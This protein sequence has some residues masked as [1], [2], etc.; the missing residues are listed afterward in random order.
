MAV[1][2]Q[3]DLAM[4]LLILEEV[5]PAVDMLLLQVVPVLED[6]VMGLQELQLYLLLALAMVLLVVVEVL[7]VM[8][9]EL[10]LVV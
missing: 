2:V 3:L 8:T 9:M 5:L 6:L 1:E 4:E 7:Q 10:L